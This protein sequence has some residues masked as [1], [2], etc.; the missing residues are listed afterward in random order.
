MKELALSIL[1]IGPR[2]N[3][4]LDSIGGTTVS[5]ENLIY[6]LD[7]NKITHIVISTNKYKKRKFDIINYVYV[8]YKVIINLP[9]INI[10]MFNASPRGILFFSFPMLVLSKLS[11]C[12]LIIRIFGGDFYSFYL[13]LNKIVQKALLKCLKSAHLLLLQ[14]KDLIQKY[15]LLGC[16]V[17][18]LPTSR[19]VNVT[20]TINKVYKKRFIY[21]GQITEQ[22]GLDFILRLI[23]S[24]DSDYILDIYGPILSDKYLFL[25]NKSYYKGILN[26]DQIPNTFLNYDVLL[27]PTIHPGEGYPGSIIEANSCG[28]PVIA[29][30]W[31]SIPEIVIDQY[32][33]LLFPA[34]DFD[35]LLNI[36]ENL[37][38][39]S[40]SKLSSN[41]LIWSKQFDSKKI[42]MD[43]IYRFNKLLV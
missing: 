41:A 29:S 20:Y 1:L 38:V 34:N 33:G 28:L 8:L 37:N 2:R 9:R 27:L 35:S 3:N 13:G 11:N 18:W 43:L 17:C 31:M 14:T 15:E 24:L 32:N 26:Q 7:S 39:D 12:K 21:F 40:Y 19:S 22:K 10:L 16:K 25:K 42:N 6:Y 5:F 30:K 36:I 4:N 23:D